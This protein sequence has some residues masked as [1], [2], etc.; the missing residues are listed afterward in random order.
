[1]RTASASCDNEL[2]DS[3]VFVKLAYHISN[4]A[5]TV[6]ALGPYLTAGSV[7]RPCTCCRFSSETLMAQAWLHDSRVAFTY[8]C[9]CVRQAKVIKLVEP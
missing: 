9:L 4:T 5:L 2:G 6:L 7:R 8:A 3:D 1:V